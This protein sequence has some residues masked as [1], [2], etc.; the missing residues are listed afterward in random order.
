MPEPLT[1]PRQ[2]RRCFVRLHVHRHRMLL[3]PRVSMTRRDVSTGPFVEVE[4]A[5]M[6]TVLRA[7]LA[8]LLHTE[9]TRMRASFD[10][11]MTAGPRHQ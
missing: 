7:R 9:E 2:H 5:R 11:L 10:K 4:R 1:Q 8:T 3:K 6:L